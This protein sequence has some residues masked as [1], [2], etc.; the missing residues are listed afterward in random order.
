MHG[1]NNV[2]NYFVAFVHLLI[3]FL[4]KDCIWKL[5]VFGFSVTL[6]EDE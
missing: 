2:E 4:K 6:S 5:A 3:F 1:M